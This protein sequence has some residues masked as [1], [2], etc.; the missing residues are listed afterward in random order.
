MNG[1]TRE[2]MALRIARELKDGM[3]INLGIG[4]P[5]IVS[6]WLPDDIDVIFQSE[7]GILGYGPIADEHEQDLDLVNAGAQ[8]VTLLPGAS[9]FDSADSFAMIRNGL[10]DVTVLGAYQVSEK[11]DL[12]NWTTSPEGIG[13]IGGA[14]DLACGA[15]QIWA[16]MEHITSSGSPRIVRE[17]TYPLT[18]VRSVKLIFTNLA[19]IEVASEGLLL[20]ELAPGVSLD[21]VLRA[22]EPELLVSRELKEMEL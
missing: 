7:N 9:F 13:S 16:A 18:A 3:Y 15:K 21:E 14:M 10:I 19:L 1:L 17:C 22:T 5:T 4:L 11:G 8:P 2:L 20:R 12:A 6:Q